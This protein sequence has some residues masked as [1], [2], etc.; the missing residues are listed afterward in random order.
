MNHRSYLSVPIQ[1]RL[2]PECANTATD[3]DGILVREG[4]ELSAFQKFFWKDKRNI[5]D[6]SKKV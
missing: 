4:Q 6:G 2:W 1:K 3:L 5:A